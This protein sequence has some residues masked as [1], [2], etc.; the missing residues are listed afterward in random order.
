M[1]GL[2]NTMFLGT[3][4]ALVTPFA[5]SGVDFASMGRMI[6]WQIAEGIDFLV[7]LGTTGEAP[8]IS[9]DERQKIIAFAVARAAGRV[10]VVV[11][12]GGNNTD[13]AIRN[14]AEAHRLGA[15]GALVVTPYYNKPSQEGLYRHFRAVA[16][17]TE[18]PVILYNVPG[19]TGVNMQP[20]T[21]A[22]LA[23]IP[24][25]VALKE[26]CGDL[27]QVDETIALLRR[28]CPDFLVLSGNDDQT[29]HI[30]NS[31]GHGAISVL[32]NVAPARAAQMVRAC[33]GGDVATARDIHHL[34]LPLVRSLFAETSPMPVKYAVSRLGFCENRV[35][36]PLVEASEATMR[37]IDADMLAIG[38]L[39][40][41][42]E[43]RSA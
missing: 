33:L 18:I 3:G 41:F 15:S 26:A 35:R 10:P 19:R 29:F 9:D 13:H 30:V 34:T 1:R 27:G 28:V 11:G 17:M 38:A 37:R 23:E 14:C 43:P 5:E 8:V 7:V 25:V 12:T 22:R 36:L 4:T 16:E 40:A 6:D 2:Q 21:V 42:E 20:A 31:G 24:N 32:S 39:P